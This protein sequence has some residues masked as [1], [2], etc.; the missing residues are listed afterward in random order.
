MK[1]FYLELV[2]V[3]FLWEWLRLVYDYDMLVCFGILLEFVVGI[4]WD[5]GK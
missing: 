3:W 1:E 2:D 5:Y 4:V